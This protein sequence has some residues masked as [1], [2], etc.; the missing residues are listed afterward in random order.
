[1][2]CRILL[3]CLALALGGC[4]SPPG[5]P[6]VGAS[7][8]AGPSVAP[9]EDEAPP[10]AGSP[11]P[12]DPQGDVVVHRASGAPATPADYDGTLPVFAA[13]ALDAEAWEPTIGVDRDGHVV[14]A[15]VTNTLSRQL[16]PGV[17]P[18]VGTR[19]VPYVSDDGGRTWEARAPHVADQPAHA[20]AAD[21]FLHV[22]PH[23]GRIFV[24]DLYGGCA[25]LS[26]SDDAGASWETN[27]LG[28]GA[29]G[30]DHQA[31]FTGPPPDG[32]STQGYA[33][34]VY[35]C[36]NNFVNAIACARSLD[37]G[38]TFGPSAV[39]AAQ[40]AE[41][42]APSTQSCA[43]AIHAPDGGVYS[44]V[45][46]GIGA[47][48]PDGTAY[49]PW[50]HCGRFHLGVSR[51]GGASWENVIVADDLPTGF[52]NDPTVAIDAAG[53]VHALWIDADA[54]VRLAS[55]RDEGVTWT[56]GWDAGAPGLVAATFPALTAGAEGRVAFA[57]YGTTDERDTDARWHAYVGIVL[58]ALADDPVF[59]TGRANPADDPIAVGTCEGRCPGDPGVGDFLG[60][61][62]DPRNG[63]VWVALADMCY[64]DQCPPTERP[65]GALATAGVQRSGTGLLG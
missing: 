56:S 18:T 28:C 61:T 43:R 27:P 57:Y 38:A 44:P 25:W 9:P 41:D 19:T 4:A 22:D 26:W 1:M 29:A 51:D 13:I 30:N 3:L 35:Y 10:P 49:L 31:V 12:G 23:T 54:R 60:M 37:G 48:A 50:S 6:P 65:Y 58:D 46:S 20:Y 42:G 17:R 7:P 24:S 40:P 62:H 21:P 52:V 33:N 39:V 45:P 14:L 47:V 53:H 11:P 36:A 59:A 32:V 63:R 2:A 8:T 34:V 55:S 16:A 5:E 64:R 15:T